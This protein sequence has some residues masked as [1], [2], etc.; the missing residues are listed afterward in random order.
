MNLIFCGLPGCGK[1]TIAKLV[2]EELGCQFADTDLL[3]EKFYCEQTGN[4]LKTCQI[5]QIIGEDKFRHYEKQQI[6]ALQGISH[7]SIALGGGALSDPDNIKILRSLGCVIYLKAPVD[8]VWKRLLVRGIPS[9]V[10]PKYP[11][12]AFDQIAAKR[13]PIYE[14][15]AHVTIDVHDLPLDE[16]VEAVLK[17]G[18]L[19]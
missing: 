18:N 13:I 19:K 7:S 15:A 8:F 6:A 11:E 17:V 9:F 4:A 3:I 10:D 12:K 16:I 1:T 14:K 2:S 5:H